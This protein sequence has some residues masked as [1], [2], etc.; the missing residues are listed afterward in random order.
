MRAW[1]QYTKLLTVHWAK[2]VDDSSTCTVI[3]IENRL[4]SCS[5]EHSTTFPGD[6]TQETRAH[7]VLRH[8][9]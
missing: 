1:L 2:S 7:S 3:G 5:W 8:I 9:G 6:I 4:L